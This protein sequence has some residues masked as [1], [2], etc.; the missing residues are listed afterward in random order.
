MEKR[1]KPKSKKSSRAVAFSAKK[2]RPRGRR[3]GDGESRTPVRKRNAHTSTCL[4]VRGGCREKVSARQASF[5]YSGRASPPP[6]G[7]GGGQV[8]VCDGGREARNSVPCA[9]AHARLRGESFCKRGLDDLFLSFRKNCSYFFLSLGNLDSHMRY[10]RQHSRQNRCIPA[11]PAQLYRKAGAE[12]KR[13]AEKTPRKNE[14]SLAG[15]AGN[16]SFSSA[17]GSCCMA[18]CGR[19]IYSAERRV[20]SASYCERKGSCFWRFRSK[21]QRLLAGNS[22][23]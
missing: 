8:P 3:A 4:S 14:K 6:P 10:A 7:R 1:V 12:V 2:S 13:K 11:C 20:I 23:Y 5:P 15:A 22:P 21:T 17:R 16:F 9:P 18:S 19:A